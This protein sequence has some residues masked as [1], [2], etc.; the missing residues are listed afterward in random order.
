MV[1]VNMMFMRQGTA[2]PSRR[3]GTL[4][5]MLVSRRATKLFME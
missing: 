3:T 1:G 2:V 5:A 4:A